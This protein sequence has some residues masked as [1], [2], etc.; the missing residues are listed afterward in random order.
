M[1]N[2]LTKSFFVSLPILL[3]VSAECCEYFLIIHLLSVLAVVAVQLYSYFSGKLFYNLRFFEF[4]LFADL[5]CG[6]ILSYYL[7]QGENK[8]TGFA[9]ILAKNCVMRNYF[10]HVFVFAVA[11]VSAHLILKTVYKHLDYIAGRFSLDREPIELM[12]IDAD[13]NS[14]TIDSKKAKILQFSVFDK[15]NYLEKTAKLFKTAF[16]KRYLLSAIN[17]VLGIFVYADIY[18]YPLRDAITKSAVNALAFSIYFMVVSL[19]VSTAL[20]I[21]ATK[22]SNMRFVD[23]I[24]E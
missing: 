22:A 3:L 13:L 1:D 20:L 2:L 6:F 9:S 16:K 14:G 8:L 12:E 18:S 19:F 21:Y 10:Q 23:L 4:F 7:L 15:S 11:V 17:F 24:T 5:T